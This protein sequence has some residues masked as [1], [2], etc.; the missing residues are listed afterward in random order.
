MGGWEM[1]PEIL[2]FSDPVSG[3]NFQVSRFIAQPC[4]T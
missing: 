2:G 4:L 1:R 3:L